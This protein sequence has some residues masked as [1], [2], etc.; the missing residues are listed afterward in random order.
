MTKLVQQIITL[1]TDFGQK[2][3]HYIA[4]MKGVILGINPNVR[5]VDIDH[6]ISPFSLYEAAYILKT[7]FPYFPE[8]TIFMIVVDPGVGSSREILGIKTSSNQYFVGPN[9]GIFPLALSLDKIIECV[10]IKNAKYFYKPVSHTFHGRDIMAPVAGYISNGILLKEF[11]AIFDLSNLVTLNQTLIINHKDK[12][13]DCTIQYI[14]TFGNCI[15]NVSIENN[16]I[17]NTAFR[18]T[19]GMKLLLNFQDNEYI[20]RYVTHFK[21]VSEEKLICIKGSTN[22]LEISINQGDAAR[23]IGLK[24]GD[25]ISIKF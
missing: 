18:L 23:T 10:N 6:N 20:A 8:H 4:S 14:D 19:E 15:T 24:L 11:G 17:Q 12:I 1:I 13:I 21:A 16:T 7:V 5:I 9:N 3:A 25:L 22:L 2:G